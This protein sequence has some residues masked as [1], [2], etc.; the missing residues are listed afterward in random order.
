[1][2]LL[3]EGLLHEGPETIGLARPTLRARRAQG[4]HGRLLGDA[5]DRAK[6]DAG[7]MGHVSLGQTR[8]QQGLH[9]VALE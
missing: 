8:R 6:A 9:F 4:R 7:L 3:G 2:R 1:M 5:L